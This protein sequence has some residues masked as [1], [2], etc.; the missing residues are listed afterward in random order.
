MPLQYIIVSV[1]NQT[2]T[3]AK[4]TI[5]QK[6][7]EVAGR[8]VKTIG[9]YNPTEKRRRKPNLQKVQVPKEVKVKRVKP[10]AG[11]KVLACSRCIKSVSKL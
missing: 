8:Y 7:S 5:C 4:C 3:M 11:K 9:Q 2:V 1:S 6:S 10:F